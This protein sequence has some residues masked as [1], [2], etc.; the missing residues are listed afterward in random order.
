MVQRDL[1]CSVSVIT[2]I[3][4]I[5]SIEQK[6]DETKVQMRND[7]LEKKLLKR[8]N[9]LF[10][11][12][13]G[14]EEQFS[15]CGAVDGS[16]VT[17]Q[18]ENGDVIASCAIRL[19]NCNM[20]SI[21]DQRVFLRFVPHYSVNRSVATAI[22]FEDEV[23]LAANSNTSLVMLDGSIFTPIIALNFGISQCRDLSTEASTHLEDNLTDFFLDYKKILADRDKIYVACLKGTERKEISNIMNWDHNCNELWL[24][25]K[26][27]RPGEYTQPSPL[28]RLDKSA[29]G[30]WDISY[31][32][33]RFNDHELNNT[34][35]EVE[36]LLNNTSFCFYKPDKSSRVLRLEFPLHNT[37]DEKFATLLAGIKN[38]SCKNV[39]IKEPELLYLADRQAKEI[40]TVMNTMKMLMP[41]EQ[42]VSLWIKWL[43]KNVRCIITK[44]ETIRYIP[45]RTNNDRDKSS[46]HNG[47]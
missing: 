41:S 10:E 9:D 40:H 23:N 8:D 2:V 16:C 29:K 14:T 24:M 6:I 26:V 12:Y 3:K 44:K 4:Y 27:L 32:Y 25:D 34:I 22:M 45:Y 17:D 5:K 19:Y 30:P 47:K 15:K 37:H 1:F 7:L 28:G 43:N 13:P 38:G 46:H 39:L 21:E 36:T 33:K 18:Y 42:K 20:P 31:V 11:K 35:C